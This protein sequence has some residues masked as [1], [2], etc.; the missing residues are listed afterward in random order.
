M[1]GDV[2]SPVASR[3][4]DSVELAARAVRRLLQD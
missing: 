2:D 3:A 1:A 4:Q